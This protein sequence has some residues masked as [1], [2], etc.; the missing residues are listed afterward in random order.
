L[1]S[2]E[3]LSLLPRQQPVEDVPRAA[4]LFVKPDD[5]WEVNDVRHHHVEWAEGLEKALCTFAAAAQQPGPI[6]WPP[7]PAESR[8]PEPAVP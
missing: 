3:W 6:E 5:R 1:R 7:L 2:P 8:V 4:Q